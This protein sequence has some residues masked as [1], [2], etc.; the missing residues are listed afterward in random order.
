MKNIYT[1]CLL[2]LLAT[3]TP[4]IAQQ[5]GKVGINTQAP[6]ATLDIKSKAGNT[7]AATKALEVQNGDGAKLATIFDDGKV[8]VGTVTPEADFHIESNAIRPRLLLSG[9]DYYSGLSLRTISDAS[10]H[11][12]LVFLKASSD[13]SYTKALLPLGAV[14]FRDEL[15]SKSSTIAGDYGGAAIY[16][17]TTE[18]VTNTGKGANLVLLYY[19]KWRE[20]DTLENDI[21]P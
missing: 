12:A 1:L 3:A 14:A 19:K 8:G 18:N 5:Q 15:S 7:T 17:F 2:A 13:G 4:A 16:S 6:G 11:P 9:K 21:R 10:F 20:Y